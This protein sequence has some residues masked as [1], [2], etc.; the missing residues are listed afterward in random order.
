V[1]FET[2]DKDII[3]NAHIWTEAYK[4]FRTTALA[5]GRIFSKGCCSEFFQG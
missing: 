3:W 5:L 2:S 4:L 1:P